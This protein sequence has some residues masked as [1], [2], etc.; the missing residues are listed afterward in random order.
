MNRLSAC[1][2]SGN[3]SGAHLP[4]DNASHLR[5]EDF[6]DQVAAED[7]IGTIR[8]LRLHIMRWKRYGVSAS[9]GILPDLHV[10]EIPETREI[11]DGGNLPLGPERVFF[12]ALHKL[13]TIV[14]CTC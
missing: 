13:T 9:P 5:N 4:E 11:D 12:P 1:V 3:G 10:H 2:V 7:R 14:F 6:R 8:S